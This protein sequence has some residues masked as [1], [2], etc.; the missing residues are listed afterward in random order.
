M[1]TPTRAPQTVTY[2]VVVICWVGTCL[3]Q[4]TGGS[5]ER[6]GDPNISV[7]Y[8]LV[9]DK[10]EIS[11]PDIVYGF[12]VIKDLSGNPSYLPFPEVEANATLRLRCS[13]TEIENDLGPNGVGGFGGISQKQA[14]ASSVIPFRFDW[15]TSG[16]VDAV[17]GGCECN[18]QSRLRLRPL[19]VLENVDDQKPLYKKK[20]LGEHEDVVIEAKATF[21]YNTKDS[22]FQTDDGESSRFLLNPAIWRSRESIGELLHWSVSQAREELSQAEKTRL[23]AIESVPVL[24]VYPERY[25]SILSEL[26]P[27]TASWRFLEITRLISIFQQKQPANEE[28]TVLLQ[29]TKDVLKQA[30]PAEFLRLEHYF[31]SSVDAFWACDDPL[32]TSE[33]KSRSWRLFIEKWIALM[34]RTFPNVPLHC[35][36][37]ATDSKNRVRDPHT[38]AIDIDLLRSLLGKNTRH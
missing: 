2:I 17:R 6:G 22:V 4:E 18:V 28:M 38:N 20:L 29:Q 24:S 25:K 30:G 8:E 21:T 31:S 13:I 1:I 19:E 5:I 37:L 9:L 26:D 23:F 11:F 15:L 10:R 14:N 3:A 35:Q 7:S 34:E 12:V 16:I 32:S 27:D 33:E 36:S